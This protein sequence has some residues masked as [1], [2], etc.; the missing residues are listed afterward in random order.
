MDSFIDSFIDSWQRL[1]PTSISYSLSHLTAAG[2]PSN[3]HARRFG[4]SDFIVSWTAPTS[5]ATVTGYR[6]YYNGGTDQGEAKADGTAVAIT[7][8]T[9]GLTYSIEIVALSSH[10]PSPVVEGGVVTLG[11]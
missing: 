10:L 6:V 2:S 5:G 9:W 8:R 11:K 7:N 3:I 4:S 1:P